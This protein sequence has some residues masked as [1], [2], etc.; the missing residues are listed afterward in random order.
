MIQNKSIKK[1]T[2]RTSALSWEG[3]VMAESFT[4]FNRTLEIEDDRLLDIQIRRFIMV[5]ADNAQEAFKKFYKSKLHGMDDL[6]KNGESAAFE[7]LRSQAQNCAEA[8][9]SLEIYDIS[10]ST[11]IENM[12]ASY[13]EEEFQQLE[14]WYISLLNDEEQKDAYRKARRQN[15][16]RWVSMGFGLNGA[17]YASTQAGVLN[18]ASGAAHGAVNLVGKSFSLVG[19]SM[20]KSGMYNDPNTCKRLAQALYMDVYDWIYILESIIR[21]SDTSIDVITPSDEKAA[22]NLFENLQ[23]KNLSTE[24]YY[25]IAFQLFETNPC[26]FEYYEYCVKRFPDQQKVLFSLADYCMIDTKRLA[27]PIFKSIFD[28]M[29]HNT[30]EETLAIKKCLDAK[31][32]E[33]GISSSPTVTKVEKLL[34][35]FDIAARTFQNILFETREQRAT[36]EKDYNE[37]DILCQK[38]ETSSINECRKMRATIQTGN[39]DKNIGNLFLRRIDVRVDFLRYMNAKEIYDALLEKEMKEKHLLAFVKHWRVFSTFVSVACLIIFVLSKLGFINQTGIGIITICS[40][41]LVWPVAWIAQIIIF[42]KC[43]SAEL[44]K[45]SDNFDRK[46]TKYQQSKRAAKEKNSDTNTTQSTKKERESDNSLSN[47]EKVL[48]DSLKQLRKTNADYQKNTSDNLI[49]GML[50]SSL[51]MTIDRII[52]CIDTGTSSEKVSEIIL[53]SYGKE[54]KE[55]YTDMIEICNRFKNETDECLKQ[56]PNDKF[57]NASRMQLEEM[58]AFLQSEIGKL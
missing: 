33:L 41:I 44:Q 22:C 16:S 53:S 54:A 47:N 38:I 11:I 42:T 14:D 10:A 51:H 39:Y 21:R 1:H 52:D 40:A 28:S 23:S 50:T 45:A 17:A 5:L 31:Q 29:P 3:L 49:K 9:T 55:F 58:I 36:A 57:Q 6:I 4:L 15:R 13:F 25:N 7:I 34:H 12:T 20:S 43:A 19:T 46:S 48:I 18:L 37:L 56:H 24:Q 8:L 35:D 27:E 30:E 2:K 26:E 32:E